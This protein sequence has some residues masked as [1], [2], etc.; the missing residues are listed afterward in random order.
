M[1]AAEQ[2][3]EVFSLALAEYGEQGLERLLEELLHSS[4]DECVEEIVQ[5]SIEDGHV[6][7]FLLQSAEEREEME[8]EEL[9]E[10]QIER[11]EMGVGPLKVEVPEELCAP[12]IQVRRLV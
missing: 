5:D 7:L 6:P 3:A 1:Q 9:H 11:L 8:A 2:D 12:L 10:E 4:V